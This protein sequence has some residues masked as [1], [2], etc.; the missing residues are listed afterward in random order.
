MSQFKKSFLFP[1]FIFSSISMFAQDQIKHL[2][3]AYKMLESNN[4]RL[5]LA[6]QSILDKQKETQIQRGSI[7]PTFKVNATS[8]YYLNLPVQLIPAEIFGGSPGDFA[9][10]RF[11]QPWVLG[12]GMEL[13]WSLFNPEKWKEIKASY[14]AIEQARAQE[15]LEYEQL[16]IEVIRHY[17]TY[18][19]WN[20]YLP[21]LLDLKEQVNLLKDATDQKW[22]QEILSSLDKNRVEALRQQVLQQVEDAKYQLLKTEQSLKSVF[23]LAPDDVLIIDGTIQEP[24]LINPVQSS[25]ETRPAMLAASWQ[26][27]YLEEKIGIRRSALMPTVSFISR[28]Q[29]QWQTTNLFERDRFIGF[30]F[31]TVGLQMNWSLY[32]GNVRKRQIEKA[33]I[34]SE[35]G[36]LQVEVLRNDIL[37]ALKDWDLKYKEAQTLTQITETRLK[38]TGDNLKLALSRMEEGVSTIDEYFQVYQEYASAAQSY[39]QIR[40]NLHIYH[41]LLQL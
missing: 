10:V 7:L 15:Q 22:E 16:K 8:D 38:L 31:G 41:A 29:F 12:T 11:G 18:L 19:F 23:F 4:I 24:P 21:Y 26:Q 35:Q 32:Q 28:Y 25:I 6:E 3:D 34:A 9:E 13:Q 30:D 2:E 20:D 27:R 1:L 14:L 40:L 33:Q 17:F 37:H 36:R 39:Y 5:R